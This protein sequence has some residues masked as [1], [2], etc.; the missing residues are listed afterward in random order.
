MLIFHRHRRAY[1]LVVW[2]AV[3]VQLHLFF[4][5][6]L[7]HHELRLMEQNSRFS[8]QGGPTALVPLV[9]PEPLDPACQ[10]ARMGSVA[11]SSLIRGEVGFVLV[12]SLRDSPNPYFD[13]VSFSDHA[14]RGPPT[15]S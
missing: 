7:H 3:V 8:R 13:S 5:A 15:L 14:G 12:Q 11:P 6:Q 4:V 9:L 1:A 10:I 2:L